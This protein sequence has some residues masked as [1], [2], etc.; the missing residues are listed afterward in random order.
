MAKRIPVN[1]AMNRANNLER[2]RKHLELY[3]STV[4]GDGTV[5]K[6]DPLRRALRI[7]EFARIA[8]KRK[9]K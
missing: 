3:G 5:V 1:T 2:D 9:V 8:N 4:N 6:T 7:F